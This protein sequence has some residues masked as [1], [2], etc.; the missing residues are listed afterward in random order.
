MKKLLALML[1]LCLTVSLC[2]MAYASGEPSGAPSGEAGSW[3]IKDMTPSSYAYQVQDTGRRAK[4]EGHIYI[5][6]DIEDGALVPAESNWTEADAASFASDDEYDAIIDMDVEVEGPG[7]T[8]V[9]SS[10]DSTVYVTGSYDIHDEDN[11][12]YASDFTGTGVSFI[13]NL[14]SHLVLEGID[15]T[16]HGFSRAFAMAYGTKMQ[17]GG[18]SA[19]AVSTILDIRNCDVKAYG[20]DPFDTWEGYT[21][22][23]NTSIMITP[24]YVLGIYGG[25]R[26]LNVLGTKATLIVEDSYLASG[27]W[28]VLSS[29]GCDSPAFYILDSTLAAIPA[30]QGGSNSGWKLF[31]YDEDAYGSAYGSYLI[32]DAQEYF[33][34]VQFEGL[35]YCSIL[36]GGDAWIDSLHKGDSIDLVDPATGETIRTYT[37][38]KDVISHV[39]TVFGWMTH[40]EGT[41]TVGDAVVT[42]AECA[43]LYKN[44]DVDF[45]M[46]GTDA[47]PGNGILLQMIDNDD[48]GFA[49]YQTEAAGVLRDAANLNVAYEFT[50]DV[51]VQPGKTYYERVGEDEY[52]EVTNPENGAIPNYY[53]KTYS[54]NNVTLTLAN[55]AYEGDIWNGTGYYGENGDVLT[56]T[57]DNAGLTGRIC[58]STAPHAIALE[59]RNVDEILAAIDEANAENAAI[60]YGDYDGLDPIKYE[61]LDADGNVCGKDG[62]A[63]IHFTRWSVNQYYL[64]GHVVNFVNVNGAAN[65]NVIVPAGSTWTVTD[66]SV[67]SYLKVEGTVYGTVTENADGT[68]TVLPGTTAVPAGEYGSQAVAGASGEMGGPGASSEEPSGEASSAASGEAS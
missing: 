46:D 64:L 68:I 44:A 28:G 51:T 38:D 3:S 43:F 2:G 16:S 9:R 42:P 6:Y 35:T 23:A 18:N 7:F 22:S 63:Y 62:A 29:D 57:L 59:G 11:G 31:G 14:G 8:A 10:G 4:D 33:H 45:T 5:G 26:T 41:I 56:V 34:G 52:V 47:R 36:T 60:V 27:G 53:E 25:I 58:L 13:S 19:E 1:T 30:S 50:S 49:A 12:Y 66:E 48:N 24:P 61:F 65:I 55:N 67:I 32:G 37:A 40:N 39:N 15:F 54:G 21:S 17:L 20:H